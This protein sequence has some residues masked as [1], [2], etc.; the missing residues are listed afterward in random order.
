MNGNY[1]PKKHNIKFYLFAGLVG[2]FIGFYV[3][4]TH[5]SSVESAQ[6]LANI[7]RYPNHNNPMYIYHK[8]LWSLINQIT[9]VFLYYGISEIMLCKITSGI[10]GALFFLYSTLLMQLFAADYLIAFA[11]PFILLIFPDCYKDLIITFI[12]LIHLLHLV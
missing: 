11:A 3:Y 7:V 6:V 8:K 5:Q 10:A 1:S 2:F 9:A 4:P 12:L